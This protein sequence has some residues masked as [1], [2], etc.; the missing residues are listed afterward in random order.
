MGVDAAV[1]GNTNIGK[2]T[3]NKVLAAIW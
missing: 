1:I 2:V 3:M